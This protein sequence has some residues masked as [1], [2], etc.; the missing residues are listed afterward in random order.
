MAAVVFVPRNLD[1]VAEVGPT[2]TRGNI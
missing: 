2:S 1:P